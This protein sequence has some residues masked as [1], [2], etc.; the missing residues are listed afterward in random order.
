MPDWRDSFG[1]GGG[2]SGSSNVVSS[3]GYDSD[4]QVLNWESFFD[5]A[6]VPVVGYDPINDLLVVLKGADHSEDDSKDMF[7]YDFRTG[8]WTKGDTKIGDCL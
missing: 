7:I 6:N 4:K 5:T 2:G 1:E 8:S 3:I